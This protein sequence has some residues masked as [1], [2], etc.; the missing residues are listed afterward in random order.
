MIKQSQAV[1]GPPVPS[2][3]SLARPV[4]V[5]FLKFNNKA[6]AKC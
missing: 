2:F 6:G 5:S 3:L 1:T 4:T